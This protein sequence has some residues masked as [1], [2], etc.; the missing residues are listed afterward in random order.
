MLRQNSYGTENS[1]AKN[2]ASREA[3]SMGDDVSLVCVNTLLCA[4]A[5]H[6]TVSTA[7]YNARYVRAP[8]QHKPMQLVHPLRSRRSVS[9]N[10]NYYKYYATACCYCTLILPNTFTI[11]I[12]EIILESDDYKFKA[13][14]FFLF[15][16]L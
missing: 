1:A 8:S 4:C 5:P 9:P 13:F 6:A 2:E 7:R 15:P 14:Y 10:S 11:N 3:W 12:F 16:M